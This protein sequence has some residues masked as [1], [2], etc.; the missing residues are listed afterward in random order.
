MDQNEIDKKLKEDILDLLN[1]IVIKLQD[2]ELEYETDYLEVD[3]KFRDVPNPK[4]TEDNKQL[5]TT[6]NVCKEL[7]YCLKKQEINSELEY[8]S[9]T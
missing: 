2:T 8:F 3:G 9:S 1:Q 5:R 4:W 7:I 6:I